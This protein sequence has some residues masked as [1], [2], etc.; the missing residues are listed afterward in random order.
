MYIENNLYL[1]SEDNEYLKV[2]REKPRKNLDEKLNKTKI[3]LK[4]GAEL[5]YNKK[6]D[7]QMKEMFRYLINPILGEPI[8]KFDCY[9]HTGYFTSGAKDTLYQTSHPLEHWIPRTTVG[10]IIA[11]AIVN[12]TDDYDVFG[13]DC[14]V[15]NIFRWIDDY[16][17]LFCSVIVATSE[18]NSKLDK[19]IQNNNYTFQQLLDLQHYRDL[20]ITLYR[21][22]SRFNQY[23]KS[24]DKQNW[25]HLLDDSYFYPNIITPAMQELNT[26]NQERIAA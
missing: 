5:F 16:T 12:N 23:N 7:P 3:A 13:G 19:L 11:N 9:F 1:L 18:E 4:W 15:E 24:N 2:H 14:S 8:F 21:N 22:Y 26:N 17:H 20:G 10:K 6:D 25:R